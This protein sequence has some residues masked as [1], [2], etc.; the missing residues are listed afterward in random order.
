MEKYFNEPLSSDFTLNFNNTDDSENK[1]IHLHKIILMVYSDYFNK[2]FT[3]SLVKDKSQS[4]LDF[5]V[6]DS[7]NEKNMAARDNSV[8][9]QYKIIYSILQSFYLTDQIDVNR[10]AY[11]IEI[12]NTDGLDKI[13]IASVFLHYFDFFCIKNLNIVTPFVKSLIRKF[14]S[15]KLFTIINDRVTRKIWFDLIYNIFSSQSCCKL[16]TDNDL[17]RILSNF[18]DL[19]DPTV[20]DIKFPLPDYYLQFLYDEKKIN[21]LMATDLKYLNN[22]QVY[23]LRNK[24]EIFKKFDLCNLINHQPYYVPNNFNEIVLFFI[25]VENIDKQFKVYH[26]GSYDTYNI[27]NTSSDPKYIIKNDERIISNTVYS[28]TFLNISQ[29]IYLCKI[30]NEQDNSRPFKFLAMKTSNNEL[31]ILSKLI[32]YFKENSIMFL[33]TRGFQF[34]LKE[35]CAFYLEYDIDE[36]D[37]ANFH[38]IKYQN[39]EPELD[40][41]RSEN[42]ILINIFSEGNKLG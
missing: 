40:L 15:Q 31:K 19:A 5:W 10:E 38:F 3:T 28:L 16:K 24:D 32:L 29:P 6:F 35:K 20:E 2:Y 22:R 39:S 18:D 42:A 33:N 1:K 41:I 27:F 21:S 4:N 13:E 9:H 8:E 12:F 11:W 23:I 17:Y 26:Y 30:K 14:Q 25:Y 37:K 7:L 36:N 34:Q